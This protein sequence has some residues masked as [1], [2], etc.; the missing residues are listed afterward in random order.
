MNKYTIPNMDIGEPSI[1]IDTCKSTSIS[2]NNV[3]DIN[4]GH[5]SIKAVLQK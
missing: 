3:N 4:N 1:V 5:T 2:E